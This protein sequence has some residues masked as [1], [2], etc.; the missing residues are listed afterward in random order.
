MKK[1]SSFF[2]SI[3]KKAKNEILKNSLILLVVLANK[4]EIKTSLI[5]KIGWLHVKTIFKSA[6]SFIDLF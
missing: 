3:N 1:I 5:V 2:I 4:S 6:K